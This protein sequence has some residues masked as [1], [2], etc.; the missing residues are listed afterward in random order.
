MAV[1]V[2]ENDLR[3]AAL[4]ELAGCRTREMIAAIDLVGDEPAAA[5]VLE[6]QPSAD[7][8]GLTVEVDI[9]ESPSLMLVDGLERRGG[10]ALLRFA[11]IRVGEQFRDG[12]LTARAT[13]VRPGKKSRSP[14][15]STSPKVEPASGLRGSNS[16]IERFQPVFPRRNQ[17]TRG[18]AALSVITKSLTPSLSTSNTVAEVCCVPEFEDS[19]S[20]PRVDRS[21][22]PGWVVWAERGM[23]AS[24]LRRNGTKAA[25]AV[26]GVWMGTGDPL[27]G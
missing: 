1:A 19:N 9:G 8:I 21:S 5:G 4:D 24:R 14:S 18:A 3:P 20:P 2:D 17:V 7:K 27:S 13:A 15:P 23:A 26:R 6:P 16:T 25:A 22:H 11:V 12:P 10:R